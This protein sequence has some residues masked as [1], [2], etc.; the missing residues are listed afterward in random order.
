MTKYHKAD[1]FS[2]ILFIDKITDAKMQVLW[3]YLLSGKM[4]G[5]VWQ[6]RRN[7]GDAE[8]ENRCD[9]LAAR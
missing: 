7:E 2:V 3:Y 8:E 6:R 9:Y 1:A 4:P 5:C